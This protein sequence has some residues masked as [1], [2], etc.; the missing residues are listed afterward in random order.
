MT[1]DEGIKLATNMSNYARSKAVEDWP[2]HLER[3]KLELRDSSAGSGY[4]DMVEP[5]MRT[6]YIGGYEAG[7][8]DAITDVIRK[9][10]VSTQT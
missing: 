6:C 2:K 4:L 5:T 1:P 10:K 9:N 3:I 7:Y 8:M